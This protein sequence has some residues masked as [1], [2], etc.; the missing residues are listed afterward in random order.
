MTPERW[1]QIKQIFQ[2]AIEGPPDER[3]ASLPGLATKI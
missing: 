3:D 1:Q 2:S